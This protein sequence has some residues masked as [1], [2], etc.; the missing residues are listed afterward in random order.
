MGNRIHRSCVLKMNKP[1][2]EDKINNLSTSDQCIIFQFRTGHS[3]LNNHLNRFNPE[4]PPLCRNCDH[5]YETV[6]HVLFDCQK[7]QHY[8]KELLPQQP[9]ISNVLYGPIIQQRNACKFVN[10]RLVI[11]VRNSTSF[12][13][14]RRRNIRYRNI[15]ISYKSAPINRYSRLLFRIDLLY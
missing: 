7:L 14:R 5:P 6:H 10:C 1:R 8:R 15:F 2:L 9:P 4:H 13:T 3:K 11:I 12:V